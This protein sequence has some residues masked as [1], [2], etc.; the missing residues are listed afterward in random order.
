MSHEARTGDTTIG[1]SSPSPSLL[2]KEA[3]KL[4]NVFSRSVL[5]HCHRCILSLRPQIHPPLFALSHK[6]EPHETSSQHFHDIRNQQPS[7]CHPPHHAQRQRESH[8]VDQQRLPA[9][10]DE[11]I[12]MLKPSKKPT[13]HCV[14]KEP[15]PFIPCNDALMHM[16][17]TEQP[18][19]PHNPVA[20]R[21]SAGSSAR[22]WPH[23]QRLLRQPDIRREQKTPL[24]R[25][26]NMNAVADSKQEPSTSKA[27]KS[28]AI[29]TLPNQPSTR[30]CL[31]KHSN[32][33]CSMHK[34]VL[35]P[36]APRLR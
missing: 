24:N 19:P 30:Q 11:L 13:H 5:N 6:L 7:S 35:Q 31:P 1:A 20:S 25:S 8:A 4:R 10:L 9:D 26:A 23:P 29:S 2:L 15:R 18:P 22:R 33:S 27:A 12:L 34:S 28:G 17:Q 3:P 14:L 36:S 21:D 32:K 16:R